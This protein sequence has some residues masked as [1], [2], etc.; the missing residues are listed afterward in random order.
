MR[1]RGPDEGGGRT[2]SSTEINVSGH[3]TLACNA[4]WPETLI[5]AGGAHA[6][7]GLE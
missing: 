4:K 3:L 5:L 6:F 1:L 2:V 7:G